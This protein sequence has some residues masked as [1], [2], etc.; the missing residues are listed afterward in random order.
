MKQK[1][2]K[3]GLLVFTVNKIIRK[4]K[5]RQKNNADM[6]H[7]VRKR[8]N[9]SKLSCNFHKSLFSINISFPKA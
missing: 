3:P 7:T 5:E 6:A 9:K 8:N 2:E 1:T 4:P